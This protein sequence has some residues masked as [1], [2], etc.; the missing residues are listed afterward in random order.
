[1]GII[2]LTLTKES[3]ALSIEL[4]EEMAETSEQ[5]T[6][7][8]D[9]L[10][11]KEIAR[12]EEIMGMYDAM[13]IVDEVVDSGEII[14]DDD[15]LKIHKKVL[16]YTLN[17][18]F[19][20][21]LR[22]AVIGVRIKKGLGYVWSR[23]NPVHPSQVPKRFEQFSEDLSVKAE[24]LA[25]EDL[26][27]GAVIETAA[28]AHQEFLKIHPFIEGNGRTARLLVDY[29]FKV[30]RFPLPYITNFAGEDKS[31]YM[32]TVNSDIE[33]R[34]NGYFEKFLAQKL[35]ERAIDLQSQPDLKGEMEDL[36]ADIASYMVNSNPNAS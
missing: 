16:H 22:R 30:G 17:P 24:R 11:P 33:S 28:W 26:S 8:P 31:E 34:G 10:P 32:Q 12:Q 35:L 23:I 25:E 15:I 13:A 4:L 5:T 20:G 7:T 19:G 18:H 9:F 3:R 36:Q 1:M 6:K 14:T 2:R 21:K 27:V 29:L